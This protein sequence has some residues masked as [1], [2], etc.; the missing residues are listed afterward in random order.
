MTST[1]L[2]SIQQSVPATRDRTDP[3]LRQRRERPLACMWRHGWLHYVPFRCDGSVRRRST[4]GRE[5]PERATTSASAAISSETGPYIH[6]PHS[7]LLHVNAATVSSRKNAASAQ[8]STR[9]I[10]AE[11]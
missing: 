1:S 3:R 11:T 10:R 6:H 2:A 7:F 8:T 5:R 4:R 9:I